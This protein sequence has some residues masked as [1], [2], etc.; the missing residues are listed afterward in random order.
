VTKRKPRMDYESQLA[1]GFAELKAVIRDKKLTETTRHKIVVDWFRK[2]LQKI[3][4]K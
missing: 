1:R 4:R 2:G 3:V